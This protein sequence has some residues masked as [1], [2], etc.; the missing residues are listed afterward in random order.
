MV[1]SGGTTAQSLEGRSICN[2][3]KKEKE[4]EKSKRPNKGAQQ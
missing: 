2:A 4:K 3:Q 1:V